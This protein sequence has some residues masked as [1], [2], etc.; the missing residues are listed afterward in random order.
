[1]KKPTDVTTPDC[2]IVW[3]TL[4]EPESFNGGEPKYS[5]LLLFEKDTDF[6]LMKAAIRAAAEE[7]FPGQGKEFY[8]ALRRPL[9]D[10]K[11]KAVDKDGSP[12]PESFYHNR[13]FM[14]SK[15]K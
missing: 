14:N 5:A 4:F 8:K 9:R 2:K 7:R 1:M 15:S 12:D 11:Q 13:I 6:T 3:P 10:G